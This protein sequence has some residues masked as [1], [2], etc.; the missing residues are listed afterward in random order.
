[1]KVCVKLATLFGRSDNGEI[2]YSV[3][4]SFPIALLKFSISSTLVANQARE[5]G[6]LIYIWRNM[7]MCFFWKHEQNVNDTDIWTLLSDCAL[8]ADNLLCYLHIYIQNITYGKAPV[9]N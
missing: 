1:M 9:N 7:D 4:Q 5:P 6:Y 2:E 8:H 3:P